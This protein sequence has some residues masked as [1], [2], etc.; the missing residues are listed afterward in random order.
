MVQKYQSPVRIY[1]YPFEL[2]MAAYEKRFPTCKMIPVFVGSDTTYEFRSDDG[3]E[4]VIERKCKL[5]VECPYILKKIVGVDYVYFIQKNSLDRRNRTLKIEARN[6]SFSSRIIIN[7]NCTYTVHPENSDWTC[8]EQ[9]ASLDVKSFFGFESTVEKIAMKQYS[10]NIGKGKEIIEYYINELISEGVT[11]IEPFRDVGEEGEKEESGDDEKK[12]RTSQLPPQITISPAEAQA[13]QRVRT[14]SISQDNSVASSSTL[15]TEFKLDADYIERCLGTLNPLQESRLVQLRKWVSEAHKGKI[16]SDSTMLRF[17]RA[18]E[19][20]V[21]K[22]REMLCQSL[23]WRKKYQVDRLLNTYEIP[24]VGKDYFPGGWHHYDK[25]GRPLYILKV[26]QMDVKGHLRSIG[27]EGML[28]LTMHI[29]EEGLKRTEEQT[30]R[31]GRPISTWSCLL[32]LD[33]LNMR[34]LWRPGI[35]ALLRIIEIVEA[36]Y[37]ETMGRVFI[38]RAPRMFPI[39]WTIVSTF[40]DEKT[41]EKFILFGNNDINSTD[42]G[43]LNYIDE[44]FLPEFLGGKC[45]MEVSEGGLIPKALYLPDEEYERGS[46]EDNPLNLNSIYNVISLNRGQVHEVV[47]TSLDKGC[48]ICWDFDILKQ[49][50][51]FVVLY[52]AKTITPISQSP[53]TTPLSPLMHEWTSCLDK[54]WVEGV[55]YLKV[56]PLV[57]CHDGESIQGS[58]VT[59]RDGGAYILQ[60][61]YHEA[62]GHHGHHNYHGHHFDIIE[63]ITMPKAKVMYYYEVLKSHD[64]RGSM[65]SL[66]SFHSSVSAL[67][68]ATTNST[69]SVISSCPSR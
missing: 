60:W 36:N 53:P 24:Q 30:L 40:I 14:K 31:V 59:S 28:K 57:V 66:Q 12:P 10:Q 41:R 33:G 17:L 11:Y 4:H 2:V 26:G 8:F 16:P 49:D 19:F 44:E 3:A 51:D 54:S 32:D 63:S 5:N 64:Y 67:S 50:V 47:L 68:T 1:K 20:N 56:E 48:V 45:A 22:A 69:R 61:R 21:E 37:P 13:Q 23:V 27:E 42:S 52:T 25:D 18:R 9:S 55:D 29:C 7:E 46:S 6:D 65:S 58:H 38:V 35:K 34:H 43:L 62:I 39:L 15:E